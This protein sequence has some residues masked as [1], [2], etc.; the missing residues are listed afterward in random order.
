LDPEP[1]TAAAQISKNKPAVAVY[2]SSDMPVNEKKVLGTYMMTSLINTGR[3]VE[4]E[5]LAAF[6]TAIYDEQSKKKDGLDDSRICELGMQFGIKY[7]C[8]VSATPAFGFFTISARLVQTGTGNVFFSGEA[9]SPLKTMEDIRQ[10]SNKV[11]ESMFGVRIPGAHTEHK[12]ASSQIAESGADNAAMSNAATSK[13][14]V[15][16][17]IKAR[18]DSINASRKPKQTWWYRGVMYTED[19]NGKIVEVTQES[20]YDTRHAPDATPQ[21]KYS[22]GARQD[23]NQTEAYV[24]L[25]GENTRGYFGLVY[26]YYSSDLYAYKLSGF[27]EWRTRGEVFKVYGGPGLAL[28][29]YNYI[30][31]NGMG[32]LIGAQ[33]GVE[34]NWGAFAVGANLRLGYAYNSAQEKGS[35]DYAIGAGPSYVKRKAPNE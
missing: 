34:L 23:N 31:D 28:G 9:P 7:I 4:A 20:A 11:V 35:F 32:I 29:Y 25:F 6:L 24:R 22:L 27:I 19:K 5:G 12:P 8:I 16:S 2:V 14:K 30:S 33:V 1:E 18:E 13:P 26:S 17:Y 15:A 3:C 10:V 21:P